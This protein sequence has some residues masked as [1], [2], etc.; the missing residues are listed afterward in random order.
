MG[1]N[2]T[3]D[4]PLWQMPWSSRLLAQ[5]SPRRLGAPIT[6]EMNSKRMT[7]SRLFPRIA[8]SIGSIGVLHVMSDTASAQPTERGRLRLPHRHPVAFAGQRPKP[9][10]VL[11]VQQDPAAPPVE[12]LAVGASPGGTPPLFVASEAAG[13]G[14]FAE[15]VVSAERKGVLARRIAQTRA[16]HPGSVAT[17]STDELELQKTSNLGEV[18]ARIPGVVYVDED[19]RGTK[20]DIALRGLNPIRSE[21]V[22]LLADGVPTQPSMYSEQAAY[23]GVPA[24][25]VAAIEVIKGGA[26]V[27]FGPNTVGGVINVIAR[28]PSPRPLS[29]VLDTRVDTYGDAVGSVFL[30]GT[31]GQL[32]YGV[33]YMHKGG[34]GFRDSLDYRID[35]VAVTVGY[36]LNAAHSARAHFQYYDERSETPGGLLPEQFR[37]DR[38]LSNKPN[39]VFFG[40]RIEGDL[41]TQHQLTANQR[42]DTLLYAYF[43]QRNWFYRTSLTTSVP[44]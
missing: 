12:A 40:Q 20:P 31:S 25:R 3:G 34:N 26:A 41:R 5:A 29:L 44:I 14:E 2:T 33:E 38:S 28:A 7:A 39:D 23:Y 10:T 4:L 22:Q 42:I 15:V 6:R 19:G 35:D 24:E 9:P 21:Y 43:F 16:T 18:L 13:G 8:L 27:L 32:S 1:S 30:S 17:V 37:A 11:A 36:E